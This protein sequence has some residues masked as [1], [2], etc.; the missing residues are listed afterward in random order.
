MMLAMFGLGYMQRVF[1]E[2]DVILSG[3]NTE[4]VVA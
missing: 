1:T 4:E 3:K 2:L